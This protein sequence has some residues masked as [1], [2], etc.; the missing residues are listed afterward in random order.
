[1]ATTSQLCLEVKPPRLARL[2]ARRV[3]FFRRVPLVL[4]GNCDKFRM[5]ASRH[6]LVVLVHKL[7]GR[8][9]ECLANC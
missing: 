4:P 9:C 2:I 3:Q 5:A 8:I 6:D 1:M 7:D